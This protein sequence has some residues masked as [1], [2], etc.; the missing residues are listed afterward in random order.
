MDS[1][2]VLLLGI[3]TVTSFRHKPSF[4]WNI[5]PQDIISTTK[6][7]Q[8]IHVDGIKCISVFHPLDKNKQVNRSLY[9]RNETTLTNVT[10]FRLRLKMLPF[11]PQLACATK[12]QIKEFQLHQKIIT[13]IQ[14]GTTRIIE[15]I[16]TNNVSLFIGHQF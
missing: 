3:L 7:H 13:S 11:A 5:M 2:E 4:R 15:S 1:N 6:I 16:N 14:V 9:T 10:Y 8:G 12:F